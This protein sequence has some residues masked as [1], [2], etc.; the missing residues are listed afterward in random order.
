MLFIENMS[1]LVNQV[2]HFVSDDQ[3]FWVYHGYGLTFLWLILSTF[4]ICI[5]SYKGATT[6]WVHVIVFVI[7]DYTTLFLAGGVIYRYWG[8]LYSEFSG[9]S[10]IQQIH[11]IGGSIFVLVMVVQHSIGA[12]LFHQGY[13]KN[14]HIKQGYYLHFV[15]G[16]ISMGGWLI[17]G[18]Y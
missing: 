16:L 10:L 6:K 8:R 13:F 1:D 3:G 2:K 14:L 17:N 4:A 12:V 7:I 15:V 9:W 11:A 5:R 18:N